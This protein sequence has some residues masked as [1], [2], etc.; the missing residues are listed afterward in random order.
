MSGKY[1]RTFYEH[2]RGEGLKSARSALTYGVGQESCRKMLIRI[3]NDTC[4]DDVQFGV[5]RVIV[6]LVKREGIHTQTEQFD[7]ETSGTLWMYDLN[8]PLFFR[9]FNVQLECV[10][11][12]SI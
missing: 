2:E 11:P 5:L 7:Y 8:R 10:T 4:L 12:N 6:A 9:M 1:P 3:L